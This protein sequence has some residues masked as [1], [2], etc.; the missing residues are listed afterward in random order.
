MPNPG[1]QTG[2]KQPIFSRYLDVAGDGSGNSV[3]NGDYSSA[4]EEF[5]CQPAAGSV[6]LVNRMIISIADAV[7]SFD[8]GNYGA[9]AAL[10]NGVQVKVLD[11]DDNV[12]MDLTDAV[13]IKT[14]A[15]WGQLC[16]DVDLKDWGTIGTGDGL[17]LVRWTFSKAGNP[18]RLVGDNGH[19]LAV[20]LNDDLQGLTS[21]LFLIQGVIEK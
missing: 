7:G 5:F 16:F 20:I 18:I 17:L 8:A 21:Q 9:L 12:L 19:R 15:Q 10:T 14:N 13:P 6:I 3:A 4:P 11:D 2:S 1:L